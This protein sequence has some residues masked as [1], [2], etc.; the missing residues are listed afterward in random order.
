MQ[1]FYL[2][3]EHKQSLEEW[4]MMVP[5]ERDIYLS[6]LEAKAKEQLQKQQQA[7]QK[8]DIQPYAVPGEF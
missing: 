1:N 6:F 4:D 8:F 3:F 5:F 2:L 7:G